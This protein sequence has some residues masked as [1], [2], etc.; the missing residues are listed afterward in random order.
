[1]CSHN[2]RSESLHSAF[3]SIDKL[4]SMS[5]YFD[6]K[7]EPAKIGPSNHAMPQKHAQRVLHFF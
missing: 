4:L 1:M 3:L 7:F 5:G 6:S 2:T